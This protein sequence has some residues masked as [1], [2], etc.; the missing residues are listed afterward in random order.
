MIIAILVIGNLGETGKISIKS[1]MKLEPERVCVVSNNSGKN[2]LNSLN[3]LNN[4]LLCFHRI[5]ESC[6]DINNVILSLEHYSSYRT[7]NFDLLTS[8]KW[9]LILEVITEHADTHRVLYSDLDI[10]WRARPSEEIIYDLSD[11]IWVQYTP[12]NLRKNW[13][14]TGIMSWSNSANTKVALNKLIYN[15]N[16][17]F[18]SGN[19]AND[20]VTFNQSYDTLPIEIKKMPTKEYLIGKEFNKIFIAH[21]IYFPNL[22]CFHANYII[23]NDLKAKILRIVKIR[24]SSKITWIRYV[25]FVIAFNFKDLFSRIVRRLK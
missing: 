18:N 24:L 12:S 2:W 15:Q 25:P 11:N 6:V 13:F 21:F 9:H 16:Y 23:G 3:L 19:P 7:L 20:E 22:V 1:L 5:K 14:C 17:S 8:L 4:E 10:Y